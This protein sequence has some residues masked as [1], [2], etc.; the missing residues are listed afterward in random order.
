MTAR[1]TPRMQLPGDFAD[2]LCVM[3]D[4]EHPLLNVLLAASRNI[5]WP[6]PS[7][8]AGLGMNTPAVSK[9]IERARKLYGSDPVKLAEAAGAAG[10]VIPEPIRVHAM[11]NGKQLPPEKIAALKGMQMVASRVNGAMPVGHPD[12]RVSE[13]YSAELNQLVADEGFT[14]YYL[15]QVLGV[16]HR[17]ITSRL[18]R[19]HFRDPC[20]SVAGTAS[21]IYFG[22]KIGDPGEGAPRL[23]AA[24]RAELRGLWQAYVDGKRGAKS[25]LAPAL[26]GYLKQGFTLA[27]LSQTMTTKSSRVSYTALQDVLGR[28]SVGAT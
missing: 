14:P 6:T 2:Q 19:H 28:E 4:Q 27:N 5:G 22:R 26:R 13:R 25:L 8:A 3:L 20:P 9:R 11:I 1:S 21:G 10:V 23:A 15:A 7:L 17:A 24:E 18:E 16:S 12:R